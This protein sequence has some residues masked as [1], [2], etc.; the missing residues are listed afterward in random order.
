M[1][2]YQHI[3]WDWNGTLFDD[4]SLCHSVMMDLF[5]LRGLPPPPAA[6]QE[7]LF[8]HPIQAYYAALGVDFA[9]HPFNDLADCFFSE[10]GKRV[11]HCMPRRSA[12]DV[13]AT[14]NE[15][16]KS[17]SVLSAIRED[18]LQ[19][20]VAHVEF[21]SFFTHLAGLSDHL[22]R[23]K[24]D[25]GR[26][27]IDSLGIPCEAILLVGDTLHD[28]EVGHALG[29]DV[30]L[31]YSGYQARKILVQS[32]VTTLSC[33]TDLLKWGSLHSSSSRERAACA[34]QS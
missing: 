31:I 34:E 18:M 26:Q 33:L 4:A 7:T 22:G 12:S 19:Y 3:I 24:V 10:Y 8:A 30:A 6:L 28:A 13:L 32:G 16:G 2:N 1:K 21:S 17:Q 20:L 27:H 29:V 25:R 9:V 23:S 15:R 11:R 5:E 14:L